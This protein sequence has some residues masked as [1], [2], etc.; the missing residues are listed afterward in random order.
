MVST[1]FV[2]SL[3]IFSGFLIVSNVALDNEDDCEAQFAM[4]QERLEILQSK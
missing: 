3:I 1:S 2:R 4:I